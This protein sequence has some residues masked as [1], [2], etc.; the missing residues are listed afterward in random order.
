MAKCWE[1]RGCDEEMQ[2]ECLHATTIGDTCPSKC[3]FARCDRPSH[4]ATAD[5]E[6]IFD[7]N[8]DRLAAI[9]QE[10]TFCEFFLKNGPRAAGDK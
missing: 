9:R 7:P 2:A 1:M 4:K 3:V 6:L 10:C 5:P 8:V